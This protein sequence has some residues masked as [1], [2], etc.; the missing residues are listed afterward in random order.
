MKPRMKSKESKILNKN[1]KL[2]TNHALNFMEIRNRNINKTV[3]ICR[4]K[5]EVQ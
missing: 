2:A 1:N 4:Y 3:I 5:I